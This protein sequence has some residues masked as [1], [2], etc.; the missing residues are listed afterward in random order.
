LI[1]QGSTALANLALSADGAV[2][3]FDNIL[4]GDHDFSQDS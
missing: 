2:R 3:S 1:R 4:L